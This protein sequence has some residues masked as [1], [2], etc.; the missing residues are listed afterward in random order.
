MEEQFGD[1]AVRMNTILKYVA[2][3]TLKETAWNA[4]LIEGDVVEEVAKLKSP[5][6]G[7]IPDARRRRAAGE[8]RA[9]KNCGGGSSSRLDITYTVVVIVA[10]AG[11][12]ARTVT[13]TR[14]P[15]VFR[16]D[17]RARV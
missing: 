11:E 7:D 9:G 17:S 1:Y 4:T 16:T 3:T 5:P 2:S 14:Q 15:P 13:R 8:R 6:G 12:S 10:G